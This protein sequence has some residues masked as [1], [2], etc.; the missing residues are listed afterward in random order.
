MPK[1][2]FFP[3]KSTGFSSQGAEHSGLQPPCQHLLSV[4]QTPPYN[5]D[6]A[7]AFCESGT[8]RWT[9]TGPALSEVAESRILDSRHVLVWV[10]LS[11]QH[12]SA[13]PVKIH[14]VGWK[15]MGPGGIH[16]VGWKA[17][18]VTRSQE[19]ILHQDRGH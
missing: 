17:E 1:T 14:R 4:P 5:P 2:H 3:D 10:M 11:L 6:Q 9:D 19:E 8:G 7:L 18:N 15:S 13:E 12:M 16:R